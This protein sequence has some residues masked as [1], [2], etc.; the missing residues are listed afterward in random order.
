MRILIISI[1]LLALSASAFAHQCISLDRDQAI[2]AQLAI[3]KVSKKVP[4]FLVIDQYCEHCLDPYPRPIVVDEVKITHDSKSYYLYIN[5]EKIDIA[6]IYVDNKNLANLAGCKT[7][8]V[9]K[10]IGQ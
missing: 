5:G 2:G 1:F 10:I 4:D 6:Y 9:S 7:I 3:E 8:A